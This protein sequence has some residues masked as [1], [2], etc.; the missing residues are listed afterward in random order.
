MF[1]VN[2]DRQS[3]FPEP[4]RLRTERAQ[5]GRRAINYPERDKTRPLKVSCPLTAMSLLP[6]NPPGGLTAVEDDKTCTP[7]HCFHAFDALYCAL[8]DSTPI[9]P[10]FPDEKLCVVLRDTPARSGANYRRIAPSSSLGTLGLLV[11]A[12]HLG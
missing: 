12:V 9:S 8:T 1:I 3:Y 7:E 4:K 11:Q 6:I 5:I 2:L 10:S